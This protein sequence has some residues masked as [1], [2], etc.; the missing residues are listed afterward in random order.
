MFPLSRTFSPTEV[1]IAFFSPLIT[2]PLFLSRPHCVPLLTPFSLPFYSIC[3]LN[4]HFRAVC[5]RPAERQSMN[6]II[7]P[8]IHDPPPIH[9]PPRSLSLY[10]A[11]SVYKV[12][13]FPQLRLA[14]TTSFQGS[15]N[16]LEFLISHQHF[17]IILHSYDAY[18][19]PKKQNRINKRCL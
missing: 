16:Y 8:Q 18:L 9:F 14:T 13:L 17:Y 19:D 6:L 11:L 2:P 7:L 15:L 4:Q 1:S 3:V 10:V 5:R 12:K